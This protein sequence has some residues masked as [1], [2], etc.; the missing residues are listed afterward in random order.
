MKRNKDAKVRIDSRAQLVME[1][2]KRMQ[3]LT[4]ESIVRA[5]NKYPLS[6]YPPMA[7][8]IRCG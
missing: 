3:S 1:S 6:F 7:R 8:Q 5:D 4:K 2:V